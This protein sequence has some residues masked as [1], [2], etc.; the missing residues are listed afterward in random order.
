[1]TIG[2]DRK[3]LSVD[4]RIE[5]INLAPNRGATGL[6]HTKQASLPLFD[7]LMDAPA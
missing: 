2:K 6:A 5:W 3:S 7:Q 4:W 1:V